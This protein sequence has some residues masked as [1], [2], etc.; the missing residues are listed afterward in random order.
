MTAT[1]VTPIPGNASEVVTGGVPVTAILGG[2]N[3]GTITNPVS[4]ADQGIAEAENLYV[5]PVTG[6]ASLQGNGTTFTLLPGQSW[7]V[8]KGQTTVTSVNAATGG[9]KFSVFSY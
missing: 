8:I 5:D 2:P 7:E 1:P 9:H 4:A 6:A 3:G